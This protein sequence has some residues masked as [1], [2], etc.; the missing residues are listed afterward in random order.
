VVVVL[1]QFD[2]GILRN[3][4]SRA[5]WYPVRLIVVIYDILPLKSSIFCEPLM[6]VTVV[7]EQESNVTPIWRKT[8]IPGDCSHGPGVS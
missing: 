8:F 2:V 1:R 3:D 7:A 4:S 5:F 6:P